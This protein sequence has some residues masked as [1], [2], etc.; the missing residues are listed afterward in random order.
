MLLETTEGPQHTPTIT[1][2]GQAGEGLTRNKIG[3]REA[4]R[5]GAVRQ[6]GQDSALA[7]G[8]EPAESDLDPRLRMKSAHE[9]PNGSESWAEA[10]ITPAKAERR[11]AERI[12]ELCLL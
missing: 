11:I 4:L 9:R 2:K 1:A 12:L 8:R 10:V 6:D 5:K 3:D 7:R